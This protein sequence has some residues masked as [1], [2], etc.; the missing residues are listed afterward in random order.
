MAT[1]EAKDFATL[2]FNEIIGNLKVYEMILEND[3]VA[4]KT[5]KEK[6]KSLALKAKVTREQTSDDN[7]SQGESDED[8]IDLEVV[9][10]SETKLIGS[11]EDTVITL[12]TKEVK[13]QDKS[14]S[15][16][17]DGDEPQ[18]DATCLMKVDSQEVQPKLS[19]SNN[20]VDLFELQRRMR[21]S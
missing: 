17:E 11:E 14:E 10:D 7:D 18:N 13:A 19:T 21:K 8:V 5:T 16:S 20:N 1:K 4:S 2:P 15:D 3:G 12:R 6:A 9:I